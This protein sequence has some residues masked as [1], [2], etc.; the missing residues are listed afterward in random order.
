MNRE[1]DVIIIGCGPAGIGAGIELKK[2]GISFAIIEKAM[3]G[4]KVNIA[5]RVDNY[6]GFTKIP[7]P[8]LAM[9]FYSRVKDNNLTLIFDTANSLEKYEDGFILKCN[10]E[11]YFARAVLIASGTTE[12]KLGLEKE[13]EFLGRGISYCAICDGHF[14]RG[15]DVVVVGGGNSALKEAIHLAKIAKKVYVVHR[16]NEFRGSDKTLLELKEFSNVEIITPYV[17]VKI[18]GEEKVEGLLI[19]HRET[20]EELTLEVQGF[21]PLVG[22]DPNTQYINIDGV[23]DEWGTIPFDKTMA[24]RVEGVF[25]AGDV[26]PRAVKQI[27]LS[28]HD[29]KVAAKSIIAYLNK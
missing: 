13:D 26:L 27:Y 28:E 18:I 21:F 19:K 24:S 1:Y 20:N 14:F 2:A 12:R 16:R 11:T 23:K 9:E 15:V 4:G 22:Q 3:P 10:Q 6:P 8:D 17:P 29:G 5:P 25:A 7:G